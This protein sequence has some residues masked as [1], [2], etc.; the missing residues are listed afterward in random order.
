M[1]GRAG[2]CGSGAHSDSCRG[3]WGPAFR[4][5]RAPPLRPGGHADTPTST[6]S[7]PP[8]AL[9]RAGRRCAH[10]EAPG[11][12]PSA[13]RGYS[14]RPRR[15]VG[16]LLCQPAHRSLLPTESHRLEGAGSWPT[17]TGYSRRGIGCGCW[18]SPGRSPQQLGCLPWRGAS[19]P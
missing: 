7:E 6:L 16:L 1:R 18:A 14:P 12:T 10:R 9:E 13:P 15:P 17:R 4:P 19:T 2:G 3:G 11:G 5:R 8:C